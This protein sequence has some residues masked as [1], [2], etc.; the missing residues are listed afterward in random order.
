MFTS[1][2]GSKLFYSEKYSSGVYKGVTCKGVIWTAHIRILSR[3]Y[4]DPFSSAERLDM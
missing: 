4:M 1:S 2:I 3:Q